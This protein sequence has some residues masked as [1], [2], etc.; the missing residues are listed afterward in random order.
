[1]CYRGG[2]ESAR[3]ENARPENATPIRKGGKCETETYVTV[4]LRWK[5]QDWKT[6]DRFAGGGKREIGKRRNAKVWKAQRNLT[7][8]IM[9][10]EFRSHDRVWTIDIALCSC[11]VNFFLS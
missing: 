2:D 1:M 11:D 4:L 3:T 10:N 9:S 7:T 8:K 6:R 5:T